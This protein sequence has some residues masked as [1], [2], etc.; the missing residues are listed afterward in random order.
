MNNNRYIIIMMMVITF[1]I[2]LSHS[3]WCELTC[4][5]RH[6]LSHCVHRRLWTTPLLYTD[7]YRQ[8]QT[9]TDRHT[10]GQTDTQ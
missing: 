6:Q 10:K 8:I 2:Q 4:Y 1:I 9:S 7:R 5:Q 3:T